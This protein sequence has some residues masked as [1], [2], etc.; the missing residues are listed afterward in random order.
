MRVKTGGADDPD[1][2]PP[3]TA[4]DPDQQIAA[5]EGDRH[6]LLTGEPKRRATSAAAPGRGRAATS[7]HPPAHGPS[8][9][10]VAVPIP[11]SGGRDRRGNNIARRHGSASPPLPRPRLA[12]PSLPPSAVPG[13]G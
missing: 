2:A 12:A 6:E 11:E 8:D 3:F 10:A 4:R 1:R 9:R 5:S 13:R 7:R